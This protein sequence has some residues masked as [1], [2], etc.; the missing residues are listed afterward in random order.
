MSDGSNWVHQDS[1][2]GQYTSTS[3]LGGQEAA[4]GLTVVGWEGDARQ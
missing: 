2:V 1:P 4:N 3:Q